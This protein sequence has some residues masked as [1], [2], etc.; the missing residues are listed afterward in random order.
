MFVITSLLDQGLK[1]KHL[2]APQ[3]LSERHMGESLFQGS[4]F[5][6]AVCPTTA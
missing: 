5:L 4:L 2:L 1:I 6:S 3:P